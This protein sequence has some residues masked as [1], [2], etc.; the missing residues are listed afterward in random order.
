MRLLEELTANADAIQQQVLD[1]I[2]TRN[3]DTEYLHGFLKGQKR[4]DLFKKK[5]PV[6]D[7]DQVKPYIDRLANGEPYQIISSQP[8]LELLTRCVVF[9]RFDWIISC[10]W[11]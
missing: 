7:Y 3:A 5:V 9:D 2:L 11:R 10:V 4:R 1:Q 6:V 8:I